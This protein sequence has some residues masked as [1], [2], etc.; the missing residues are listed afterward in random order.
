MCLWL[1][2]LLG[3]IFYPNNSTPQ[4]QKILQIVSPFWASNH[5]WNSFMQGPRLLPLIPT[6]FKFPQRKPCQS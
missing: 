3:A 2:K 6:S 1:W 5:A 4:Q